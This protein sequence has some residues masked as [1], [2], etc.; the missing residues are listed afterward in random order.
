MNEFIKD[1]SLEDKVEREPLILRYLKRIF[2]VLIY[3]S[4]C[5]SL[6]GVRSDFDF[7][8][9]DNN[10][11]LEFGLILLLTINSIVLSIKLSTFGQEQNLKLSKV[12]LLMLSW[13]SLNAVLLFSN[14]NFYF[15]SFLEIFNS[16]FVYAFIISLIPAL[17]LVFC[18]YKK[19]ILYPKWLGLS[20]FL[21]SAMSS[22]VFLHMSCPS[23]NPWH[24]LG[25]HTFPVLII[26]A[27]GMIIFGFLAKVK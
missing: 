15:H 16:C 17:A 4:I 1:L 9:K 5:I 23:N 3:S 11:L 22:A 14:P 13:V 19:H 6:A 20:A 12:S 8:M 10:F 21:L 27:I 7:A 24:N 25:S 2:L 18:Y 26:S